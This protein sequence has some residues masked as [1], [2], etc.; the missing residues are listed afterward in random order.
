MNPNYNDPQ[1]LADALQKKLNDVADY[2]DLDKVYPNEKYEFRIIADT[3]EFK[4]A[5]RSGNGIINYINGEYS[6]ISNDV[7]GIDDD[8]FN[9]V[10]E[11][12]VDFLVPLKGPEKKNKTL[13]KNIRKLISDTLKGSQTTE[14]NGT[15][16]THIVEYE[17]LNTGIREQRDIVGDSIN[18]TIF[19]THTFVALGVASSDIK[20]SVKNP[21]T[22]EFESVAASKF[23]IARRLVS[24]ANVYIG[25]TIPETKQQPTSTIVTITADLLTRLRSLDYYIERFVYDGIVEPFDIVVE[26]PNPHYYIA[27]DEAPETKSTTY[28]VVISDA[29]IN[30][31]LGTISSSSVTMT[32]AAPTA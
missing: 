23:G 13:L 31:E 8:S 29:G 14:A 17:V 9:A 7:E 26:R 11:M 28:R 22:G 16:Y 5:V 18:L 6:I 27:N 1:G 4:Q 24:D 25:S 2:Y 21:V 10:I 19:V 12:R 20:V 15:T 3:D 30:G 32:L